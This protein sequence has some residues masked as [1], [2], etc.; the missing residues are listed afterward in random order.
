MDQTNGIPSEPQ[1]AHQSLTEMRRTRL[2]KLNDIQAKI[3]HLE[4]LANELRRTIAATNYLLGDGPA[5]STEP[6]TTI[7]GRR[8]TPEVAISAENALNVLRHHG[9]MH[10]TDIYR[11]VSKMGIQVKGINPAALLLSRFH[12]DPRFEK[13]GKGYYKAKDE[14]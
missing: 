2:Q 3:E 13:M 7:A 14:E 10:Y 11:S 9:P 5:I 12:L 8:R 4:A 6:Q 1:E